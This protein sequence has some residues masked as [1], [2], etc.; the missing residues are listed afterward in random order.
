MWKSRCIGG[1]KGRIICSLGWLRE[2][3][4][5]C[6][7]CSSIIGGFSGTGSNVCGF[8]GLCQNTMR[9]SLLRLRLSNAMSARLLRSLSASLIRCAISG[10]YR[11][12]IRC[13]ESKLGSGSI[14]LVLRLLGRNFSHMGGCLVEY[15]V[16]LLLKHRNVGWDGVVE[17]LGR[18]RTE[19]GV[20]LFSA[21]RRSQGHVCD[22]DALCALTCYDAVI[23]RGRGS[24]SASFKDGGAAGKRSVT[25][26]EG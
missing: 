13:W 14:R 11:R 26:S 25:V 10:I 2:R 19:D 7:W 17:R 12:V 6:L 22:M 3:C 9:L 21:F 1:G 23:V 24:S 8:M 15:R 16:G 20:V 5:A 4:G 18:Y